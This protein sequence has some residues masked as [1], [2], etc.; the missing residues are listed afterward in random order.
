LLE[1]S[2]RPL[3]LW[4]IAGFFGYW[5]I[6]V[7]LGAIFPGRAIL[8]APFALNV[9]LWMGLDV[10]TGG[11]RKIRWLIAVIPSI[12]LVALSID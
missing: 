9:L 3:L 10:V 8:I 7:T 5:G 6:G 4:L 1:S 11:Q 12:L 2:Y